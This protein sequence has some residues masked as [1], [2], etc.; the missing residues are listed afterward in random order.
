M[1]LVFMATPSFALPALN[2]LTES[3]HQVV[4]VVTGRDKPSGRGRKLQATPVR[5]RADELGIPVFTPGSLKNAEFQGQMQALNADLFVVIAFRIL[6][7]SLYSM[8]KLGSINIHG[9][10]LPKYRGAA[11]IQHALLNGDSE[12]GLSAFY[13]KSAVDTGDVINQ[14]PLAIE[15]ED[16][17]TTLAE[18]MAQLSGSFLLDTL[19]KIG[20]SEVQALEQDDAGATQAPKITSDDLL[21]D[22]N[23]PARQTNNQIR[24]FAEKPGAYTVKADGKRLKILAS[25][26]AETVAEVSDDSAPGTVT[27]GEKEISVSCGDNTILRLLKMQPEGKRALSAV[28]I[29]NGQF[30]ANGERLG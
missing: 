2:A 7:E 26:L 14:V 8:P 15:P 18:K 27:I 4:A 22:W 6:P 3:D 20:N 30:I 10:L 9:S 25:A 11:P 13:L 28:D 19:N 16:N 1:N 29:I 23:N 21:I 12:T 24:A 17:Y 5:A